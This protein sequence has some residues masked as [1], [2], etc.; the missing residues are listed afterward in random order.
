MHHGAF[1]NGELYSQLQNSGCMTIPFTYLLNRMKLLPSELE[2]AITSGVLRLSCRCFSL[3]PTCSFMNE[4]SFSKKESEV[5][6]D[7]DDSKEWTLYDA[8]PRCVKCPLMCLPPVSGTA[9]VYY[10]Q[11]LALSGLGYRMEFPV[12]WSIPEFCEGFRKLL[13]HL[14][15][16]KVHLF[17][18][19][20]GGYMALKFAEYTYK[21]PR[22]QSLILCNTFIDTS[23]FQQTFAAQTFWLIP[24]FVLKR[25]VMGNFASNLTDGDM[26]DAIDFMVERLDSLT[27]SQ[28]AS[29]LTLN[30]KDS[31]VEPHKVSNTDVTV[32]DVFDES[33]LSMTVKEEMY[34]C[35]PN[36]KRAH[37]KSGGN[38]PYLSRSAEVN[39]YLQIH[40][41]QYL[42]TR[43]SARDPS[44]IDSPK[45]GESS[46]SGGAVAA[47]AT[48]SE[49]GEGEGEE[50]EENNQVE[51]NQDQ[52]LRT[53]TSI[54]GIEMSP[55]SAESQ[56]RMLTKSRSDT[57]IFFI[58]G[59]G[60]SSDIWTS[61]LHFF[62][63]HGYNVV[64]PDLLGHGFS[65]TPSDESNYSFTNLA[66]D[67]LE[68]FDRY[69][70]R[71][72]ILV[73]HS[74]GASFCTKIAKE[75][76]LKVTKLIL[77]SGGGP[78][79]LYPESCHVFCLP[80]CI[81]ACIQSCL[82][83]R[84]TGQAFTRNSKLSEDIKVKAFDVPTYVLR[85]TM[86]GQI[87]IEGNE[88]YHSEIVPSTL[89]IH[90]RNDT[91]VT[92]D[93]VDW[94]KETIFG[95]DLKI[96]DDVGHMVMMES[97]DMVNNYI[98]EFITKGESS[99]RRT[100]RRVLSKSSCRR[101]SKSIY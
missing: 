90:G 67:L 27:Q 64:A 43:Y 79:P 80:S 94:M 66:L 20:I 23:V 46:T 84:F 22:V 6:V 18:A 92:L 56:R 58:H 44:I 57:V 73:G 97:P 87:W 45:A 50:E 11:L 95:S 4:D 68:I 65:A 12:Y 7:D 15:L 100:P 41:R 17:G 91:F 2:N 31:Y 13:D 83:D 10:Q 71:M 30:C 1:T 38:F 89:L 51:N 52:D 101:E 39:L 78:L 48:D 40:L 33:A 26:A 21:S 69:Y 85:G 88:E 72:N 25:M 3:K 5:I 54:A 29:R 99:R 81:L 24:A 14:G 36:A 62:S 96:I 93:E 8:G 53:P 9:D 74:Y 42:G 28:L 55:R 63:S 16:D 75:R 77:I 82:L 70:G 47:I 34:K 19:S 76:Y 37:L 60:G 35:F 86:Q 32:M 59:V 98:L 61:Q 49:E